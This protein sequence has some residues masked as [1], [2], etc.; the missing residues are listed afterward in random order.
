MGIYI[1]NP[2]IISLIHKSCS[3]APLWILQPRLSPQSMCSPTFFFF[4][5][6]KV[7]SAP[8]EGPLSAAIYLFITLISQ[9]KWNKKKGASILKDHFQPVVLLRQL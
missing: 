6:K 3:S 8:C 5:A 1:L 4:L 9:I 2:F 7:Q